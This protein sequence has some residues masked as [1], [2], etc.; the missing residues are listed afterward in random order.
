MPITASPVPGSAGLRSPGPLHHLT[1]YPVMSVPTVSREVSGSAQA[2][3]M[4]QL[5]TA[6]SQHLGQAVPFWCLSRWRGRAHRP[7]HPEPSR[8]GWGSGCGENPLPSCFPN[9]T[10]RPREGKSLPRAAQH[11]VT[12]VPTL[13]H[14]EG[15]VAAPSASCFPAALAPAKAYA[16]HEGPQKLMGQEQGPRQRSCQ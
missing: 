3:T 10:P 2:G 7:G 14:K 11:Q 16:P 6:R 1:R 13:T 8:Q 9:Q 15:L 5:V 12:K 4:F